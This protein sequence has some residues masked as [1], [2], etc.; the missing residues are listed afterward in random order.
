[1]RVIVFFPISWLP[2]N[3]ISW[4]QER[5]RYSDVYVRLADRGESPIEKSESLGVA[6]LVKSRSGDT[7]QGKEIDTRPCAQFRSGL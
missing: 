3:I 5:G 1:M 4:C 6:K 7:T 2:S